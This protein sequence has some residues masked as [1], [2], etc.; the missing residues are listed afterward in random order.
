[1][2]F[3][4]MRF[5]VNIVSVDPPGRDARARYTLVRSGRP[6]SVLLSVL[7]RGLRASHL[8]RHADG[9]VAFRPPPDK[10]LPTLETTKTASDYKKV[11]KPRGTVKSS[12][13]M[14]LAYK[15]RYQDGKSLTE[16]AEHFQVPENRVSAWCKAMRDKL[17]D[18]R[19]LRGA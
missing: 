16:V 4:R 6:G 15:M 13:K 19:N 8:V 18:Q 11:T 3:G 2:D 5:E 12:P 9:H 17:E 7:Q 1:M 10:P 14:E